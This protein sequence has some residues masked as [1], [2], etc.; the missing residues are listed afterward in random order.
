MYSSDKPWGKS[1]VGQSR[2][3]IGRK[4]WIKKY[5]KNKYWFTLT[6]NRI[7]GWTLR[8]EKYQVQYRIEN[9][10]RINWENK[11]IVNSINR[12]NR[13]LNNP[14]AGAFFYFLPSRYHFNSDL[15]TRA[16][17]LPQQMN[18]KRNVCY[19]N[20]IGFRRN[21]VSYV[22]GYFERNKWLR[23]S[24]DEIS[25][26]CISLRSANTGNAPCVCINRLNPSNIQTTR[27]EVTYTVFHL[28]NRNVDGIKRKK[29]TPPNDASHSKQFWL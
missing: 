4:I 8:K 7:I 24:F 10:S 18:A 3:G 13:N 11:L 6:N 15:N 5:E 20:T 16:Q 23:S 2:R 17:Q 25:V 12:F 28:T 1:R 26:T 14:T 19:T 22:C 29:D 27:N 9:K 21:Y